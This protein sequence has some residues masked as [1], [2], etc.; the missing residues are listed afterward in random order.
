MVAAAQALL[1]FDVQDEEVLSDGSAVMELALQQQ[2][3]F[4]P[5]IQDTCD[6]GTVLPNSVEE[7]PD[8]QQMEME[9][10]S[11]SDEEGHNA[12]RVPDH[13]LLD[14]AYHMGVH[15]SNDS[16]AKAAALGCSSA[17][18]Y[19]QGNCMQQQDKGS[20]SMHAMALPQSRDEATHAADALTIQAAAAHLPADPVAESCQ[21]GRHTEQALPQTPAVI[22][23]RPNKRKREEDTSTAEQNGPSSKQRCQAAG[24]SSFLSDTL[25]SIYRIV[26]I[27]WLVRDMLYD[28]P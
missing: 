7:S 19:K 18:A 13:M 8:L 24:W 9:M 10:D 1:M 27:V 25:L 16:C 21:A 23:G 11:K 12:D 28:K 20:S 14:P 15:E 26:L 2:L 5:P 3:A 6:P 17:H 4:G 22:P